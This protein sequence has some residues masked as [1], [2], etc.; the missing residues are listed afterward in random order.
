MEIEIKKVPCYGIINHI[1][2]GEPITLISIRNDPQQI[3]SFFPSLKNEGQ[4][5]AQNS[6][7]TATTQFIKIHLYVKRKIDKTRHATQRHFRTKRCKIK[8]GTDSK[9]NSY[10][11]SYTFYVRR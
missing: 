11:K 2:W 6:K 10:K 3:R 4:H 9:G 8:R 1:K 5:C 7:M